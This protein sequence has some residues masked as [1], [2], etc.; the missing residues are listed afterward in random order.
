MIAAGV[1]VNC[2]FISILALAIGLMTLVPFDAHADRP[3]QIAFVDTGNT[4]RSV[5]AEAIAEALIARD[6][7]PVAVIGRAV[8]MNPFF[9]KPEANMALLLGKQGMDVS[10]HRAVQLTVN[11]VRHADL[12]ITMTAKHRDTIVAQYRKRR[13]RCSPWRSMGPGRDTEIVDA[14]GKDMTVY[15]QVFGQINVLMPLVLS[16]ALNK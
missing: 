12:I 7:L 15:E 13:P 1:R 16:K 4:G 14:Y 5:A 9:V 2:D 11:D 8:D 3:T 6:K 10:A